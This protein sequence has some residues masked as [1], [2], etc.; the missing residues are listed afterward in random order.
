MVG[1]CSRVSGG[2]VGPGQNPLHARLVGEGRG[3]GSTV[4]QTLVHALGPNIGLGGKQY[5]GHFG[6]EERKYRIVR[7]HRR[8][9]YVLLKPFTYFL[10]RLHISSFYISSDIP[11][12][13]FPTRKENNI[14][15]SYSY[16][17]P[18]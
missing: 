16:L 9:S 1:A 8:F 6:S 5:S 17:C 2:V 11:L 14:H 18:N 4:L 7:D 12:H 10:E 13:L 15:N 3:P